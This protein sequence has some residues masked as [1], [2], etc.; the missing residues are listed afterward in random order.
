VAIVPAV[1]PA[2]A[3]KGI[4]GKGSETTVSAGLTVRMADV[5]FQPG[6]TPMVEKIDESE[7]VG[8]MRKLTLS[9]DDM[10]SSSETVSASAAASLGAVLRA[11]YL[12]VSRIDE[13]QLTQR[14]AVI[15]QFGQVRDGL[16]VQAEC[17]VTGAFVRTSDARILWTDR[18]IGSST[19]R[20]QFTRHG[21]RIR[22]D[23]QC[24]A[25]AAR[26]G[27]AWLRS[28]FE[29]YKRRFEK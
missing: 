17:E 22:R 1:V 25:D 14:P 19:A 6:L 26:V 10:W 8:A 28:S 9:N 2:S 21:P 15:H 20:T 13:M 24:L 27:Y 29:N 16:E 11:D 23:E 7:I 5:L 4:D 18:V 3:A 12:F